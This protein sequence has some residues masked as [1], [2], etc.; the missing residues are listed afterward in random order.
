MGSKNCKMG[1]LPTNKSI[2]SFKEYNSLL[3]QTMPYDLGC[4]G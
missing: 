1:G 2:I 4:S 3:L